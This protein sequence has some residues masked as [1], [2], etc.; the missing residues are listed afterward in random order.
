[1]AFVANASGLEWLPGVRHQPSPFHNDRALVPL[2]MLVIHCISLPRGEY[3][4]GYVNNLFLGCLDCSAHESFSSLAGLE[5]S[6]HFLIERSGLVTQFVPLD[7]R[8]WHAG[9]SCFQEREGINDYSIGIELEGTDD[10]PFTDA[11]YESLAA[12]TRQLRDI[13]SI[14]D[15]HIVGHSDIA[16]GR[17]SDPGAGFDWGRYRKLLERCL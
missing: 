9:L 14:P 3:G 11:Q 1:M 13:V 12:L 6:A 15:D 17:K 5:V 2:D 7:K 16:P 4:T 10:S 8:A